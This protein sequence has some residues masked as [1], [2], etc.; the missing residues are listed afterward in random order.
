MAFLHSYTLIVPNRLTLAGSSNQ[1]GNREVD[2]LPKLFTEIG[3]HGVERQAPRRICV[4]DQNIEFRRCSS[5][6][7]PN[8]RPPR[9]LDFEILISTISAITFGKQS[10][11][12]PPPAPAREAQGN[13]GWKRK[14]LA[15]SHGHE[16]KPSIDLHFQL[17]LAHE[18][19]FSLAGLLFIGRT[20]FS[21]KSSIHKPRIA[22]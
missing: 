8:P 18:S 11:L 17:H 1:A 13:Q 12:A 2:W 15:I 7:G 21:R 10:S 5:V 14:F 19:F 22:G 16:A 3:D 4:S 6:V 9:A 20:L